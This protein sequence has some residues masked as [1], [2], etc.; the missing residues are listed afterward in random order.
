MSTT[1]TETE[2][3]RRARYQ[4]TEHRES[5]AAI[6]AAEAVLLPLGFTRRKVGKE[7]FNM[8]AP[9]RVDAEWNLKDPEITAHITRQAKGWNRDRTGGDGSYDYRLALS[10]RRIYSR[11]PRLSPGN[12]PGVLAYIENMKETLR[13]EATYN[14]NLERLLKDAKSMISKQFPNLKITK[15]EAEHDDL[16]TIRVKTKTGGQ[17][18]LSLDG[19]LNFRGLEVA[20][21]EDRSVA[22]DTVRAALRAL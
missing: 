8:S 1:A 13:N 11:D 21:D 17:F 16:V 6:T 7:Y 15:I 22:M 19:S 9:G 14:K 18:F 4:A 5:L 10:G 2:E 12:R 3:E 20:V